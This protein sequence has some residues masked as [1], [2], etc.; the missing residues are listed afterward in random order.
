MRRRVDG[1]GMYIIRRVWV[2][3]GQAYPLPLNL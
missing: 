3:E 1:R 2:G